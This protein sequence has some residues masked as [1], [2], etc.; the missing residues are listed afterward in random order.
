M[1]DIEGPYNNVIEALGTMSTDIQ[2]LADVFTKNMVDSDG[3]DIEGA[4]GNIEAYKTITDDTIKG[5]INAAKNNLDNA[6]KYM[7]QAGSS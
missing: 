7:D 4:K 6:K 3:V 2:S 1:T 5:Y